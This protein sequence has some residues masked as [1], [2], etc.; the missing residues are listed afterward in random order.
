QPQ[1]YQGL[2]ACM[3]LGALIEV[4]RGNRPNAQWICDAQLRWVARLAARSA[5][6]SVLE[7]A[8]QPWV[9]YGRLLRLE[10]DYSAALRHFALAPAQRN[11]EPVALGPCYISREAWDHI[12]KADLTVPNFL[13]NVYV[14]E[15]LKTYFMQMDFTSALMFIADQRH[16]VSDAA[17]EFL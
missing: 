16:A 7:L 2:A 15:S 14:L 4:L 12:V 3:N 17:Q 1:D 5:S 11:K 10:G 13:W 9:N 6:A 8:L